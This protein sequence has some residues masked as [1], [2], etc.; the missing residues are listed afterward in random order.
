MPYFRDCEGAGPHDQRADQVKEHRLAAQS[1]VGVLVQRKALLLG[2][3][4]GVLLLDVCRHLVQ[5][6]V[7]RPFLPVGQDVGIASADGKA[8][9]CKPFGCG[10]L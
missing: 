6:D 1:V 10:D 8:P 2:F 9:I 5:D 7:V 3:P 4:L